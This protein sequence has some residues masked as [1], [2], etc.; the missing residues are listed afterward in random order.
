MFVSRLSDDILQECMTEV[1]GELD[2]LNDMIANHLY[3]SEFMEAKSQ[4]ASPEARTHAATEAER[5]VGQE[6]NK[7]GHVTPRSMGVSPRRSERDYEEERS[8]DWQTDD[9]DED[10]D[11]D[12]EKK[13]C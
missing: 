8:E 6:V 4:S 7:S 5:L 12:E 2:D 3:K 9:E 13:A 1:T 10:E 11:D